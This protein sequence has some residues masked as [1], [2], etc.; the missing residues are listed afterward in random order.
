MDI[1]TEHTGGHILENRR[2]LVMDRG[3][4]VCVHA[5]QVHTPLT[6]PYDVPHSGAD[7]NS[8]APGAQTALILRPHA[9]SSRSSSSARRS[10]HPSL[11][12]SLNLDHAGTEREFIHDTNQRS[13]RSQPAMP[14]LPSRIL[15]LS[16]ASTR[17]IA[18]PSAIQTGS[19]PSPPPT[20]FSP[21]PAVDRTELQIEGP[22]SLQSLGDGN[23][24]TT[25]QADSPSTGYNTSYNHSQSHQ[26]PI[27]WSRSTSRQRSIAPSPQLHW[28]EPANGRGSSLV[29][30]DL[31][32]QL[33]SGG[34]TFPGDRWSIPETYRSSH[35]R[36]TMQS[37]NSQFEGFASS[38]SD[39]WGI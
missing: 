37:P 1:S 13:S 7:S 11:I 29:S 38:E 21:S 28:T 26:S 19:A 12:S 25:D 36:T 8:P 17:S 27:Y 31:A 18:S 30:V 4:D 16:R 14:L 34:P 9:V 5:E 24:Y 35:A 10:M 2:S 33:S 32:S 23:V 20:T 39:Y 22:T 6:G 15:D 3:R